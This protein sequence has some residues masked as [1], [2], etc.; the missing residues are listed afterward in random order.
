M[1]HQGG[2]PIT[3]FADKIDDLINLVIDK[4]PTDGIILNYH[5]KIE[6]AK[7]HD[8]SIIIAKAGP[9]IFNERQIIIKGVDALPTIDTSAIE[10]SD[11]R[12]I[13]NLLRS[14]WESLD[15]GKKIDIH[16]KIKDLLKIYIM[17][18]KQFKQ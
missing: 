18:I 7:K 6:T 15:R 12:H 5:L 17:Y 9:A 10:E 13:V 8:P 1:S 16:N 14:D 11:F 4:H 3:L 2:N